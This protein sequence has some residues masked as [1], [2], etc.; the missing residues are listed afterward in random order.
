MENHIERQIDIQTPVSRVWRALTDHREFG[1]WFGVR[2]DTPFVAG[3]SC[4]GTITSPG[5][6]HLKLTLVVTAIEPE[7]YFAY[8]WHPYAVDPD[9]DYSTESPTLVEFRLAPAGSGTLLTVRESGFDR[10]P[11]NRQEEAFRMNDGGWKVQLQRIAD[12]VTGPA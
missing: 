9:K 11:A 2:L 8:T 12:Y 6:E 7:S 4:E 10:L 3:E 5:Y 1:A